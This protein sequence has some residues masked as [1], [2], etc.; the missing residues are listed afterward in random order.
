MSSHSAPSNSTK[1]HTSGHR[2][3]LRERFLRDPSGMAEYEILELL[4]GYVFAR[5]DTKPLAKTLLARFGSIRGVLDTKA[6]TLQ[7]IEG[8]GPST[9]TFFTLLREIFARY[10][11]AP[12]YNHDFASSPA[13]IARIARVRL[14]RAAHEE[15]W[16]AFLDASNRI[17]AWEKISSGTYNATAVSAK[18]IIGLALS[19]KASGFI[20]VHNH[21]GGSLSPSRPDLQL[22]ERVAN[23]AQALYLRFVDHVIITNESAYSIIG[24]M[25]I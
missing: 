23:A 1:S 3:R 17:I 24:E 13:A 5:K 21:P 11:E 4:L 9:E 22:T 18:D 8:I 20:L 12:L 14:A 19:L 25:E 6:A 7:T 16:G 15:L 2:K 10:E